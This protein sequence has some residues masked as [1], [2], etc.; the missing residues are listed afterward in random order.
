[1][2]LL[3]LQSK[4]KKAITIYDVQNEKV[5]AQSKICPRGSD[6]EMIKEEIKKVSLPDDVA[7]WLIAKVEKE[8]LKTT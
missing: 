3:S 2:W 7:D 4:H 5:H 6:D 8:K 1:M